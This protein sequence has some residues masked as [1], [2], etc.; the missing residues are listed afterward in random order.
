L[1]ERSGYSYQLNSTI[2]LYNTLTPA[3]LKIAVL[4]NSAAM[5]QLTEFDEV[6]EVITHYLLNRTSTTGPEYWTSTE[7]LQYSRTFRPPGPPG[8]G[9]PGPPPPGPSDLHLVQP[10][11]TFTVWFRNLNFENYEILIY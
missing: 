4:T 2:E 8:L 7:D 9:P 11:W 5:P 6:L 1:R 3:V 10:G